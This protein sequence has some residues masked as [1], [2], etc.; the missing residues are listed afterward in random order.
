MLRPDVMNLSNINQQNTWHYV[1][2]KQ[3]LRN[4]TCCTRLTL[5]T[6]LFTYMYTIHCIYN[7]CYIYIIYFVYFSWV[8]IL[9][10]YNIRLSFQPRRRA[11]IS[12]Y[13]K[14]V[15]LIH[16]QFQT[17]IRWSNTRDWCHETIPWQW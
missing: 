15:S 11:A 8:Y 12:I 5:E 2:Y 6:Y 3:T 9:Y 17:S 14:P 16:N 13:C 10:M 1:T 4:P 7:I